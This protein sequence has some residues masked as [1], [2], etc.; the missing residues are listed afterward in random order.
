MGRESKRKNCS[1]NRVWNVFG[2][3]G[4]VTVIFVICTALSILWR[5]IDEKISAGSSPEWRAVNSQLSS[6]TVQDWIHK[7]GTLLQGTS[8]LGIFTVGTSKIFEINLAD[9]SEKG[10]KFKQI[11]E[12]K[13]QIT[14]RMDADR[15]YFEGKIA[16]NSQEICIIDFD[17]GEYA[18]LRPDIRSFMI[19]DYYVSCRFD[20]EKEEMELLI[21]CCPA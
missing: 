1:C 21:F 16:W 18:V 7:N 2:I 4:V 14:G 13:L 8:G 3:I 9:N 5:R 10:I 20:G 6:D 17:T 12:E 19:G 11:M 15:G